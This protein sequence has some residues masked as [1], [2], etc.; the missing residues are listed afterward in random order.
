MTGWIGPTGEQCS[1]LMTG[2]KRL[3]RSV[4]KL[5]LIEAAAAT[6]AAAA[7]G[8]HCL[9]WRQAAVQSSSPAQ[10]ILHLLMLLAT[11]Y[12]RPDSAFLRDTH[13]DT[14]WQIDTSQN[15]SK[16]LYFRCKMATFEKLHL[17]TFSELLKVF[18]ATWGMRENLPLG[19]PQ[20]RC[21]GSS[22]A[23]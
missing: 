23:Q 6:A 12:T 18:E 11:K 19:P 16:L 22:A 5:A 7:G 17:I 2:V 9:L 1:I 14:S 15:G 21:S 8:G 20:M 10:S 4:D 13:T 3:K